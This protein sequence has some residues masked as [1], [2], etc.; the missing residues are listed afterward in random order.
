MAKADR[1]NDESIIRS[2]DNPINA[3]STDKEVEEY[4][5][6]L[7]NL[8]DS[9]AKVQAIK[10]LNQSLYTRNRLQSP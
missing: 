6:Y 8:E 7:D 10:E 1:R 2:I 4:K 5:K 3:L 9:E